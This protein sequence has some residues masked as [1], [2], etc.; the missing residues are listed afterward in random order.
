ML[1]ML[2]VADLVDRLSLGLHRP[3]H[4]QHRTRSTI[5]PQVVVAGAMSEEV[6]VRKVHLV[7]KEALVVRATPQG[8]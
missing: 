3:M 7:A 6:Q 2:F 4:S 8:P 1:D 5:L